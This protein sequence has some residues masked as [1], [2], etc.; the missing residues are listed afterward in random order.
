MAKIPA[1]WQKFRAPVTAADGWKNMKIWLA[2]FESNLPSK[3]V[4]VIRTN[5]PFS[6]N[7]RNKAS[8]VLYIGEGNFQKRFRSHMKRWISDLSTHFPNLEID[9]RFQP[10]KVRNNPAAYKEVEADLIWSFAERYGSTP[11]FN[12]QFEYHEKV[13]I[14]ENGFFNVLHPGS[15]KG[16]HWGLTPLASNMNYPRFLKGQF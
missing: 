2:D 11:M 13:H 15:G 3:S 16:Y 7:Y 9:V 4:Y 5:R 1:N 6:I 10:I 8:P 12:S 14:Y